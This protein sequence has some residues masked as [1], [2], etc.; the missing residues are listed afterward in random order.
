MRAARESRRKALEL[1]IL[2]KR[3]RT[4]ALHAETRAGALCGPQEPSQALGSSS[5]AG[6]LL[7]NEGTCEVSSST[8]FAAATG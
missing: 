8:S 4:L 5:L 1:G 7:I 3:K 2:P 6:P